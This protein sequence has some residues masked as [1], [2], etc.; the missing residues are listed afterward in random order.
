MIRFTMGAWENLDGMGDEILRGLRGR[1]ELAVDRGARH[2]VN[3]VKRTLTGRRTGRRYRVSRT[4]RMHQ[5]SAPGE[6]P[7]VLYGRLRNSIT[8]TAPQWDGN[9]VSVEVGTNVVYA[10]RLEFGGMDAR[11]VM[12]AKRPYM[13]PTVLREEAAIEALMQRTV[14]EAP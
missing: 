8:Q 1:A 5:A 12:I 7:A 13:E 9:A 11:G 4:G 6:P 3:A 14:E 2:L 10:R